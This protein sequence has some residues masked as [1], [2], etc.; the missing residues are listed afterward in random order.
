M[1]SSRRSSSAC[2]GRLRRGRRPHAAMMRPTLAIAEET[3]RGVFGFDKF[4]PGQAEVIERVLSG[5]DTLGLMPNGAGKS[6]CYQ[7]P[8]LLLDGCVVVISP[9]IALMKDQI[10]GMPPELAS[11]ARA[12]NSA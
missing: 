12:V 10:D 7:L 6:L 8:A 4:R 1:G 5:T 9:L 2:D 11:A 3:L